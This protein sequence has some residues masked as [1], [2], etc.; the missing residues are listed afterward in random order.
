MQ[1]DLEGSGLHWFVFLTLRPQ[2][3]L[4]KGWALPL[5]KRSSRWTEQTI[6]FAGSLTIA[7]Y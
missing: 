6:L 7:S 2:V 5:Q 1:V 3:E 4:G